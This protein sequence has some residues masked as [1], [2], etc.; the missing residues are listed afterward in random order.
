MRLAPLLWAVLFASAATLAGAGA[1]QAQDNVESDVLSYIESQFG[2]YGLRQAS[3]VV[4]SPDDA[5]VY[6][7]SEQD[8]AVVHFTRDAATGDLTYVATYV[9]GENNVTGL[10]DPVD[11]AVSADGANLYVVGKQDDAVVVFASDA[12]DGALDLAGDGSQRRGRRGEAG[13]PGRGERQPGRR[14]RLRGGRYGADRLHAE[15]PPTARW[16]SWKRKR[17]MA[18]RALRSN[19]ATSSSARTTATSM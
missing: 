1:A 14:E 6:V 13:R 12:T 16:S 19:C 18:A 4:V 8:D 17:A 5:H 11:L 9:N 3:A 15:R 10:N 7:A 2:G